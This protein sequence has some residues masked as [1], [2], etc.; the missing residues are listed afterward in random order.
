MSS[1]NSLTC[2][3]VGVAAQYC[4]AVDKIAKCQIGV[5][6]AYAT[7]AGPVLLDRELYLPKAWAE[8]T[9][10]RAEAAVP[11][12]VTARPEP[13]LGQALLERAFAAGVSAAWPTA[14]GIYGGVYEVR[15]FLEEWEYPS[16]LA[17]PSTQRA[18]LTA[19]AAQVVASWPEE[20]WERLS[21][22][23]AVKR[24]DDMTG[25]A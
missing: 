8:D 25:R 1:S 13:A 10:R 21:A 11:P 17:V 14:D 16:V 20:A 24:R 19:K 15:H 7:T 23:R 6:L 3:S 12:H 9:E 2:K 22:G 5:F 4:G 18:G